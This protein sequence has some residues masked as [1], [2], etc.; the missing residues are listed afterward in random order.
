M[1]YAFWDSSSIIPLCVQQ[2]SSVTVKELST[3]YG[4]IVWW[5]TSVEFSS[6][7]ARLVRTGQISSNGQVQ[8]LVVFDQLRSKWREILPNI[9]LRERAE[10]LVDRFPCSAADALQLAAALAWCEGHPRNRVLISGDRQLLD[11]ARKLGF[12]VIEG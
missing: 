11:A 9:Q 7:V 12:T 6:S 8:A 2:P 3:L 5:G 4:M 1:T 10:R